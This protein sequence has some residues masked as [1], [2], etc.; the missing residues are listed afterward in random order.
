MKPALFAALLLSL[1]S[2]SARAEILIYDL[3]FNTTGP[4]VNYDFLQGGYL[5]V[6]SASNAVTSVV[7]LN[8]P[9]TNIPYYNTGV[10]SGTYMEMLS[11]GSGSEF[12]VIT[13]SSSAGADADSIAFQVLGQTSNNVSIGGGNR[14]SIARKLRGFLLASAAESTSL[15]DTSTSTVFSYGFAGS[16]KV[17]ASFQGG[18]TNEVNT[19]RLAAA[20]ALELLT[21]EL[22]NR[23]IQPEASPSPSASPTASATASPSATVSISN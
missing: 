12:A 17:T 5:V 13:S 21:T 1:C 4:S 10:L 2:L 19:G 3:S 8:D 6:D 18:L 22:E 15:D 14:L 20:D 23:G 9:N 16:S 11:E 7:I